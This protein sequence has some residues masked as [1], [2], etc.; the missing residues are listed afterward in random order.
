MFLAGEWQGDTG[1]KGFEKLLSAEFACEERLPLPNWSDTC[2]SLTVWRRRGGKSNSS[3]SS[4]KPTAGGSGVKDRSKEA[5]GK[6]PQQ[7][8]HL[9][10]HHVHPFACSQCG[11]GRTES[12]GEGAGGGVR[13]MS[14]CRLSYSVQFC[15]EACAAAGRDLHLA[16]LATRC[17]LQRTA[18][19][20]ERGDGES[21]DANGPLLPLTQAHFVKVPAPVIS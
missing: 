18:S 2:Y 10:P 11:G 16:E 15:S 13:Q 3:D 1:T 7:A 20:S 12:A 19:G 8:E 17:F 9:L 6:A 5:G 4:K 21:S 14:R